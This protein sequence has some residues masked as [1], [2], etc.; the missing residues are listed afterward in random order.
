[1]GTAMTLIGILYSL[2]SLSS[3][4][5]WAVIALIFV[6]F[7]AF[8]LTW[9]ILMRIWV[10]ESQPLQTR[11]S[12]SSL[13]LTVN[14]GC[15]FIIAFTTPIFLEASPCGPYFLWGACIWVSVI[16]FAIFLPETKGQSIDGEEQNLALDVKVGW[17]KDQ[18]EKRPG[19]SR[20]STSK[21]V[22][23]EE[24]EKKDGFEVPTPPQ[25]IEV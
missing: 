24:L 17:L 3:S 15:N 2:P 10:S 13:A 4:G 6:Y 22:V 11:A 16:V 19:L 23:G 18:L 14:W 9:A 12:V 21:T 20:R 25:T 5:Q 8:I 7:I 1:M